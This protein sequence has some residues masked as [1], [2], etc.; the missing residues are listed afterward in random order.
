MV[1]TPDQTTLL[2]SRFI[3]LHL[4]FFSVWRLHSHLNL[5]CLKELLFLSNLLLARCFP[6][7]SNS[8]H[9]HLP[10]CSCQKPQS[11]PNC[12]FPHSSYWICQQDPLFLSP[13]DISY[14]CP[15]LCLHCH[16]GGAGCDCSLLVAF[17]VFALA[18]LSSSFSTHL[19]GVSF[20]CCFLKVL[21]WLLREF[22]I[23]SELLTMAYM[24]RP[25]PTSPRASWFPPCSLTLI[26]VSF[27]VLKQASVFLSQ[28]LCTSC[29]LSRNCSSPHPFPGSFS[30]FRS[31]P[32]DSNIREAFSIHL[33]IIEPLFMSISGPCFLR[34]LVLSGSSLYFSLVEGSYFLY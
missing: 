13:K 29:S 18:S 21:Q 6:S 3:Y 9:N 12:V 1:N 5:A 4:D 26:T 31:S 27:Q 34:A 17:S 22:R 7:H 19:Q 32:K 15:S 30:S 16:P 2:S 24:I 25:L 28:G 10:S 23:N 14:S 11:H 8:E 20:S 33:S